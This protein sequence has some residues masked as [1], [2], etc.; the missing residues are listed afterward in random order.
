MSSSPLIIPLQAEDGWVV[1]GVGGQEVWKRF[2][3]VIGQE[4]LIEA[5]EFLTNK[6][7]VKNVVRL[8]EIVTEWTSKRKMDDDRILAHGGERSL[9]PDLECGAN[10]QRPA[11]RRGPGDDR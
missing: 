11:Y 2:C 9:F 8:E 10:L 5:P 7:R 3:Q 1:I 6:D 4:E